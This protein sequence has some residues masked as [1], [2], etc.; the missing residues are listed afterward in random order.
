M[1]LLDFLDDDKNRL[2]FALLAAAGPSAQ[3]MGFGQRLQYAQGLLSQQREGDAKLK[4]DKVNA[5]K[6]QLELDG[7]RRKGADDERARTVA[8]NFYK[9][10]GG[11]MPGMGP[12][13]MVNNALPPEFQIGPQAD[14]RPPQQANKPQPAPWQNYLSLAQEF[15]RE[16]LQDKAIQHYKLAES[17]RPK[18]NQTPQVVRD[19]QTG[20]LINVLIGDDGSIQPMSYGVK[21][22]NQIVGLG[23]RQMV[24][25]KNSVNN[26]QSFRMGMSPGEAAGNALGWSRLSF[27]KQ[28]QIADSNQPQFHDG[29]WVT[30]PNAANPG[31]TSMPVP[32]FTKPLTELQGKSTSFGARMQDAENTIGD[33]TKDGAPWPS[34]VA[35]AGYKAELPNWL[36]GGQIAGGLATTMNRATVPEAAQRYKQAQENWVTANLRLESGAAIGKDEMEKD[37]AKWFPQ[38]GDSQSV[39]DQKSKARLVAQRGMMAQAGPG[40]SKIPDIVGQK[41]PQLLEQLPTANSGN[42]GQLWVDEETGKKFKSN[43]MQWK[44]VQ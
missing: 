7:L 20:Q 38:P 6:S 35:R 34:T 24:V 14:M 28:K 17:F 19:P 8:Q 36:P 31:G 21:P 1:G 41:S 23:D 42:R 37:V 2:G 15:E 44:E 25:D 12:T 16:G 43:G 22:D 32:G 30:R 4:A 33:I 40:A 11:G 10:Q 3:P 9:T 13:A 18:I 5:E 26:G 27:D 39:I 29:N